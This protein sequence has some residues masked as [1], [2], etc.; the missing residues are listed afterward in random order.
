MLPRHGTRAVVCFG[1]CDPERSLAETGLDHHR[2]TIPRA[3]FSE[4]V[5]TCG[6]FDVVRVS[7]LKAFRPDARTLPSAEVISSRPL[8]SNRPIGGLSYPFLASEEHRIYDDDT[9]DLRNGLGPGL[10]V[11]AS[12]S[13]E[14]LPHLIESAA[15]VSFAEAFPSKPVRK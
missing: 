7:P 9:P 2:R 3:C 4:F 11:P 14:P 6:R 13:D 1:N 8:R 10:P 15:S 5:Y 12:E